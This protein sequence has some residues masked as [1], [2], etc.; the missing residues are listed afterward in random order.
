M[1]Y[2]FGADIGGTT[3]KLVLFDGGG[4][5]LEK[6]EILTDTQDG[7][8]R[9]L[10]DVAAS[11]LSCLE[12]NGIRKEDVIGIGAGVPGFVDRGGV[13]LRCVNLGWT[14]V[15]IK[16]ELGSLTGLRVE[17][18]NDADAAAL[19]E[20]RGRSGKKYGDAVMLTLGTGV[21][22][23]IVSGGKLLPGARGIAGELG[24]FTV[25][26]D[27]KESCNCGRKGCLEQYASATGIAASARKLLAAGNEPS[28]L[29]DLREITAK[30]VFDLAK[31]G[32]AVAA[33]AAEK[34][35]DM[36]GRAMAQFSLILD[37]EAYIIGGGVSA[38]GEYLRALVE[39]YFRLYAIPEQADTDILLAETGN[40]AGALGAFLLLE[41]T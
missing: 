36:L 8:S 1:R 11:V 18:A 31:Q 20:I 33:R 4:N 24:H 37:P 38:A 16:K 34:A 12:R 30:D 10:G 35:A 41:R 15:D 2:G 17:A 26:P 39:K 29:R 13:A 23:G 19:G 22:G 21:G 6:W 7:G 14:N 3:V 28:A 32:D 40:G 5:A 9:I 27:E 25:D